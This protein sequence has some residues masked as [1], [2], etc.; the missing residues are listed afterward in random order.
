MPM[1]KGV[2]CGYLSL[3]LMLILIALVDITI[4][5]SALAIGVI[6]FVKFNLKFS[7]VAYVIMNSICLLLAIGSLYA[8]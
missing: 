6:A 7:L 5:A 1:S 3:K 2:C 8:I 4:G